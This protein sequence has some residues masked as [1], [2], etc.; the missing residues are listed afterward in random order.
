MSMFTL[1]SH[2]DSK[3]SSDTLLMENL[4]GC[5]IRGRP[6]FF[7]WFLYQQRNYTGKLF[8]EVFERK[9]DL[10]ASQERGRGWKDIPPKLWILMS[11]E[12]VGKLRKGSFQDDPKLSYQSSHIKTLR[13]SVSQRGVC[14]VWP[15]WGRVSGSRKLAIILAGWDSD[16]S[17]TFKKLSIEVAHLRCRWMEMLWSGGLGEAALEGLQPIC[18]HNI[19][20]AL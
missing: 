1:D 7:R 12:S 9:E 19:Y 4:T 2:Q 8:S 18:T 17:S 11:I 20:E 16:V 10:L 14:K 5:E 6:D 13:T 15:F 3:N